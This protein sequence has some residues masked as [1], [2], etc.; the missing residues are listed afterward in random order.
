MTMERSLHA[1]NAT[2]LVEMDA[3]DLIDAAALAVEGKRVSAISSNH[4]HELVG[5]GTAD[6][7]V[8]PSSSGRPSE[9]SGVGI[10]L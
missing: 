1:Q 9:A 6:S 2:I 8:R 4:T 7:W 10:A 3:S 5:L